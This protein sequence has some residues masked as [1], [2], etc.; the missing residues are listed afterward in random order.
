MTALL[1]IVIA[2][3][4]LALSAFASKRAYEAGKKVELNR[5]KDLVIKRYAKFTNDYETEKNTISKD[6]VNF[7]KP[8]PKVIG[9]VAK[10]V[11]DKVL[12]LLDEEEATMGR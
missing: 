3:A 6:G 2:L 10:E 11:F 1:W 9:I 7:L 8:V 5:V 4:V 12:E